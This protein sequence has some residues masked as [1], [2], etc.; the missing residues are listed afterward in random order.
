MAQ[1]SIEKIEQDI[2][3]TLA[4]LHGDLNRTD[5]TRYIRQY[6][7]LYIRYLQMKGEPIVTDNS[8]YQIIVRS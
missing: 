7:A 3:L 6:H 8:N 1:Q 5:W 4:F 2:E